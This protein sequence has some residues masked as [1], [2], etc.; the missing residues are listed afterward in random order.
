[1]D[2]AAIGIVFNEDKSAILLILRRD[3]PVWVLPGGGIEANETAEEGVIRE[4]W[5]ETGLRIQIVRKVGEYTPLNKLTKPTHLFEC[6]QKDGFLRI[7]CETR[8]LQFFPLNRL[9]KE[10]FVVHQAWLE[11][12]LLAAPHPIRR[13][14]HEVT[15]WKLFKYFLHS[16]RLVLRYLAAKLT[17]S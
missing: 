16:P 11:D 7:G 2:Q 4:V 17:T 8:A 3:V 5:E 12:C 9:P 14:I 10:F 6:R 15:Y 1:M 13:P